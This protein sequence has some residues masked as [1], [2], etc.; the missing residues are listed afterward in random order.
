MMTAVASRVRAH[1]SAAVALR[2][3]MRPPSRDRAS[4][5]ADRNRIMVSKTSP[6]PGPWRTSRVPYTREIM[7]TLSDP[8]VR[9]VVW[10]AASQVGKA[11]ALDTALPTPEGWTTMGDVGIGDLLY[12]ERGQPCRV[13]LAT[14]IQQGRPCYR[15]CFSDGSEIVAD[16]SHRWYIESC[17]TLVPGDCYSGPGPKTG[18]LT[19]R[20]IANTVH[21]ISGKGQLRRNRYAIPIAAPLKGT[22]DIELAVP[23][24]ALGVWLGDGH[25]YSTQFAVHESALEL[26]DR[27]IETGLDVK[28]AREDRAG[29]LT[30]QIAIPRPENE[31]RRGHNKGDLGVT[32]K[33][34]CAECARQHSM[35][36]Q[37]AR[38]MDPVI[39]WTLGERL[40]DLGLLKSARHSDNEKHIPPHYLRASES[41]RIALLRGLMDTDGTIGKTGWCSYTST[42]SRLAGAVYEL[43]VSLGFKPTMRAHPAK[44]NGRIVGTAHLVGFSAYGERPVFTLRKKLARMRP[45][46]AGRLG[47]SRRRR[48]IAVEPVESVPVRCIQVDSPSSL[49]LAGRAMIPTHNTEVCL[50]FIGS[51]SDQDP[52]PMMVVQPTDRFAQRWS[53]NRLDPMLESSLVL[54]RKWAA[55][56][57]RSAANTRMHKE[58][59][60]GHLIIAGANSPTELAG[61]PIRDLVFDEIDRYPQ[62]VG[63]EGDPISLGEQR[64][65]NFWNRTIFKVSS[66]IDADTSRILPEFLASDQRYY[67]VP[68]PHCE[69]FQVLKWRVKDAAGQRIG[70]IH[71]D[72]E[73]GPSELE[74]TIHHPET[75]AYICEHCAGIIEEKH[76]PRMLELGQWRPTNPKGSCPGFH[77]SALYSPF[78]SLVELVEIFVSKKDNPEQLKTFVNLQLG[79]PWEERDADFDTEDLKRRVENYPA[80]VPYGVG[81]LTAGVDVQD[82]RLELLVKGWGKG[83][84]SWMICHQRFYGDPEQDEVWAD[85]EH[86]LARTYEHESG[87]ELRIRATMIDSGFLQKRA[88]R[89]VRGKE[90]TRGV[91]AC[92]GADSRVQESLTRA[93][94]MNRSNVKPWT[95]NTHFFKVLLFRRLR[96]T[97]SHEVGKTDVPGYMHFGPPTKTGGDG[98]FFDQYGAE[99]MKLVRVGRRMVRVFE[100]HRVRNEAID[101]EVYALAGLYSLGDVVVKNLGALAAALTPI[102]EKD[103]D[104]EEEERPTAARR[105]RSGAWA[106]RWK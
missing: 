76:R 85:L 41:D 25:S 87:R 14:E 4:K 57:S 67:F 86:E 74:K 18:V 28:I 1:R 43:I 38:P 27:V 48:I 64:T 21:H 94:R 8:M 71:W 37:Y 55:A 3:I 42:S 69:E 23:P 90:A 30:Y 106:T 9:E 82:D 88:F 73:P 91:Y 49:F 95:I 60:G 47:E 7:D 16:E 36:H 92:K 24:Y 98:E 2:D 66:P 35:A 59:L 6:E 44:L 13:T 45:R 65:R 15:V 79:E 105:R 78:V 20:E 89:F 72:S 81:V 17:L 53:L 61:E 58:F 40:R 68:C 10:M 33:G 96:W 75:A 32:K 104:E 52:G 80:E 56:G 93:K 26:V 62:S 63:K 12:D 99:T 29:V 83:E 54:R 51:Q 46:E 22:T 102:E 34:G 103:G 39:H 97:S 11:L 50:N 100:E 5:W 84:E 70:G 19:T 31:C 77:I 101:L